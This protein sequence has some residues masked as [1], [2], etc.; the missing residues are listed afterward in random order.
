MGLVQVFL[1]SPGHWSMNNQ[2]PFFYCTCFDLPAQPPLVILPNIVIFLQWDV[3]FPV[4]TIHCGQ[5]ICIIISTGTRRCHFDTSNTFCLASPLASSPYTWRRDNSSVYFLILLWKSPACLKQL[6]FTCTSVAF[7][8]LPIAACC[9]LIA[10]SI[11]TSTPLIHSLHII[12]GT[13]TPRSW[14]LKYCQG[15]WPYPPWLV[16]CNE[17]SVFV[18]E[19]TTPQ[20]SSMCLTLSPLVSL[21]YQA[22]CIHPRVNNSPKF[23]VVCY[24]VVWYCM[25]GDGMVWVLTIDGC[26]LQMGAKHPSVENTHL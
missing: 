1:S 24:S 11:W 9:S 4:M 6:F 10:H 3:Y 13:P 12:W 23:M 22:K 20:L 7:T 8:P 25:V 15:A 5:R 2:E 21:M 26:S 17:R 19:W 16:S 14:E 18:P